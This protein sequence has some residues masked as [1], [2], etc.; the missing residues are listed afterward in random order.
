MGADLMEGEA[1]TTELRSLTSGK[2][3]GRIKITPEKGT[4]IEDRFEF[5]N[6]YRSRLAEHGLKATGVNPDL[7][8][9]EVIEVTDHPWFVGVQFHPEYKSRPLAP[10]PLFSAF[11]AAALKHRRDR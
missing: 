11:I 7:D 4:P 10:H 2:V 3:L 5:N 1:E 8:L 6:A 9:V